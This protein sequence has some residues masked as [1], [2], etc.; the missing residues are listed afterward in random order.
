MRKNDFTVITLS[1]ILLTPFIVSEEVYSFYKNFNATHGM[2]TSFIK[3]A[4]LATFG[5]TIGLR[6]RTGKYNQTGFGIIPRAIVWGLLGLTINMAFIIFQNGTISF[7]QYMGL[8][9]PAAMLNGDLTGAKILVA[10]SISTALNL[11]YAPVMMTF[12][13]ITDTHI[14]NNGGT[15]KGLLKP[16]KMGSIMASLN[17]KVQWNFVFKK[18]IPFFWI[19]AHTVTF[20]LPADFRVLFAAILGIVL[21]VLLSIA[22]LKK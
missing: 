3:F 14:T 18:T 2:V 16:I 6:I 8:S 15:I 21:G 13:K 17:W 22:S 20:L 19:P 10:F 1:A 11:I 5:E 4:I 12:H 9:D 7:L